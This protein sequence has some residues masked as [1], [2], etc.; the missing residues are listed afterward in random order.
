MLDKRTTHYK[1][2]VHTVRSWTPVMITILFAIMVAGFAN[3]GTAK[4]VE[5]LSPLAESPLESPANQISLVQEAEVPGE[6]RELSVEEKIRKA[7]GNAEGDNAVKV[8]FC[9]SSLNP[10]SEHK[11]SSAKGLFQI[12]RGTWE[13]YKCTGNPLNA[14]DNIA[15]AYKIYQANGWGASSSWKASQPCHGLD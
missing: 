11:H 3:A 6:T 4:S 9:E 1:R 2:T 7:W 14:D 10:Y 15:C 12:I 13:G 5:L 8:A